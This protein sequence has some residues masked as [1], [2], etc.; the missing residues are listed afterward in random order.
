MNPQW[1]DAMIEDYLSLLNSLETLATA[2]DE[3]LD[4]KIEETPTDFLTGSIPFS[5]GNFLIE[6]NSRLFWDATN[7]ILKIASRI[8]SSGRI[9]GTNVVTNA[10]TPYT[11]LGTDETVIA[12][13]DTGLINLLL[14]V[15]ITGASYRI[16][17]GGTS[18]IDA[19]LTPYLTDNLYGENEPFVLHDQEHL[20][21]QYTL[22]GWV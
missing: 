15:G 10:F 2:V 9:K 6:D 22:K 20:D 18:G 1:S 19:T 16:V 7:F 5:N 17:N 13:T 14:P 4:K 3:S 12:D 21:I 11:I 8:Q